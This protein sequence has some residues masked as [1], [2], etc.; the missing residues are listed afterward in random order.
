MTGYF[1]VMHKLDSNIQ[2]DNLKG[3]LLIATPSLARGIFKSSVTYI[4][5]HN[6]SGAMG[7]IINRP[8]SLTLE[9]VL[10]DFDE[11]T[12][13]T[14]GRTQVLLGG[15]VGVQRGFV[16]HQGQGQSWESSLSI[17]S[18]IFL[19]GSKDI[20]RALAKE[21]GPEHFLLAL[22]YAGWSG[23][24]LEQELTENSWLTVPASHEILFE[25]PYE[26]RFARAL[27]MLGID[28]SSLSPYGGEA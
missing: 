27:E 20:L 16:L 15:P 1:Y 5:E 17:E 8:S 23:G 10:E 11:A 12:E 4:C 7:V 22:G 13:T 2:I 24:Q 26:K 9:E 14:L 25:T 3:Q 18:E 28:Q 21:Q 19:T 6:D